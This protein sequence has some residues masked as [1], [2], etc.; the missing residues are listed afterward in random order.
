MK[1]ENEEL[2]K[3][4]NEMNDVKMWTLLGQLASMEHFVAVMKYNRMK[5]LEAITVLANC[6]AFKD[7]TTMARTQGI[8][9]GIYF[10]EKACLSEKK[11]IEE[12]TEN[13]RKNT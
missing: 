8:R 9:S 7:P 1:K 12:E 3:R 2:E 5:D 11:R 10:F 4:C 6:D 13:K